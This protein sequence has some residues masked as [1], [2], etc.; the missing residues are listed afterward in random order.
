MD[1]VVQSQDTEFFA[2][3]F[4]APEMNGTGKPWMTMNIINPGLCWSNLDDPQGLGKLFYYISARQTDVGARSLVAGA[5][6]GR[7]IHGGS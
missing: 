4:V 2:E 3:N 5:V 7:E 1:L 6:G